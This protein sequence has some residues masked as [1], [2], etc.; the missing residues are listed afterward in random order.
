MIMLPPPSTDAGAETLLFILETMDP[1]NVFYSLASAKQSM[2]WMQLVLVN[3]LQNNPRQFMAPGAK[4]VIGIIKAHGQFAGFSAYP[5]L[6]TPLADRLAALL[7][8]ANNP[9]DPRSPTY[10]A[11]I[12]TAIAVAK[13]KPIVDPSLKQNPTSLGLLSWRT[14][15][16]GSPGPR[17]RIYQSVG[18][19]SF[20]ML[21]R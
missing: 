6:S 15:N 13:A 20:Y 10:S 3:R 19:N 8:V 9:K 4:S 14:Q 18:G 7:A 16:S 21:M 12:Q 17:F 5:I 11:F 1:S 2:E